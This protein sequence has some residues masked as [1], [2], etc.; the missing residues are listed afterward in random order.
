[1]LRSMLSF[2]ALRLNCANAY[3]DGAEITFAV[4]MQRSFG[5]Q[6]FSPRE[7][8]TLDVINGSCV[9]ATPPKT[10]LMPSIVALPLH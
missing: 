7:R 6:R 5:S 1:M 3:R 2:R 8:D 4:T 10:C 9:H